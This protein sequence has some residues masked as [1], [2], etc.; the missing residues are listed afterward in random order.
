MSFTYDP[1]VDQKI[2]AVIPTLAGWASA[3]M[4]LNN[5][6][7]LVGG[8]RYDG[9]L[10]NHAHLVQPRADLKL[11][12]GKN[13]FRTSGGLYSRPPYWEDEIAQANLGP[14]R[15]W[16][17]AVGWERELLP[18][19]TA[20]ATGFYTA[21]SNLIGFAS[22]GRTT[23]TG[24]S[25]YVNDGTGQ[26]YG[27]ELMVTT[28]GPHHFG[29]LAYTLA[30]SLRRDGAGAPQ[31]LFDFDQT[32]NL[33]LVGSRRFGKDDHW[34]IGGR[35][36]FTTGKPYTPVLGA[37]YESALGRYQPQWGAINSQRMEPMHQLDL[38]IDRLW[39][40]KDWRL[41]GYL[42]VQNVY[43]HA[44]VMD[45]R[46]SPDYTQKTAIKTLPILPSIGV[47]AEF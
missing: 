34:Q 38:R 17:A 35:F 30:R 3:D 16:Q 31:R 14:E 26:T 23:A 45:Y 27:G 46:Y 7:A 18:G 4:Q 44:A 40:F 9:F 15:A 19:L 28:R 32:H 29:W 20:Q 6:V 41:S 39:R 10:R 42:D 36:Q 37:Q 22:D 8:L 47:R 25:A 11:F 5:H 33:V 43:A 1:I 13:T 2:D 21:R 12:F 24:A